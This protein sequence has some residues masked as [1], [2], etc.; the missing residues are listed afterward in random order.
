MI[1]E[2]VQLKMGKSLWH[3]LRDNCQEETDPSG[4]LISQLPMS[5]VSQAFPGNTDYATNRQQENT[6]R[7]SASESV[8]RPSTELSL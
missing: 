6:F 2:K 1:A 4:M 7:V 3:D 5:V 8:K